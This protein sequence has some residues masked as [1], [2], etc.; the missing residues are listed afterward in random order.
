MKKKKT[1]A[2][3]TTMTLYVSPMKKFRK[4]ISHDDECICCGKRIKNY[5]AIGSLWVHMNVEWVAVKKSIH[6]Q[7]C[8]AQTGSASQG[9][10][11]IGRDCA[12]HMDLNYIIFCNFFKLYNFL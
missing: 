5:D 4:K 7:D 2:T 10:F 8:E 1:N 12:K 9:M 11:P 3:N 6:E